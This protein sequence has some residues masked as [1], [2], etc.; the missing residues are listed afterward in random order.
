MENIIDDGHHQHHLVVISKLD[1][2]AEEHDDE[3]N[4][5]GVKAMVEE[6]S[7]WR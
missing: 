7:K 3:T 4:G 6:K 5:V 1:H 2:F